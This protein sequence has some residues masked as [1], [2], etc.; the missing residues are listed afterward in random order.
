MYNKSLHIHKFKKFLQKFLL[1]SIIYI[2]LTSYASSSTFLNTP[3]H[4][5]SQFTLSIHEIKQKL[6]RHFVIGFDGT[7]LNPEI[8]L[9]L[10]TYPPAGVILFERNIASPAQTK[11]LIQ[12]IRKASPLPLVVMIDQ[13]G[14][15]VARLH[16]HNG[17]LTETPS[18]ACL[19]SQSLEASYKAGLQQG[20]LL[21]SVDINL[22]LAPVI[23][24]NIPNGYIGKRGRSFHQDPQKVIAHAQA[25]I[26]GLHDAG[27][28]SCLKHFPGHGSGQPDPHQSWTDV[29]HTYRPEELEPF[30]ACI[31]NGYADTILVGH[32]FHK[33]WDDTYPASCS[34]NVITDLLRHQLGYT[35]PILTDDLDMDA[36][37]KTV[38]DLILLS[39]QAGADLLLLCNTGAGH[40]KYF[41]NADWVKNLKTYLEN[42]AHTIQSNAAFMQYLM[43]Q[44][45]YFEGKLTYLY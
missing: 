23:D 6:A 35:G 15:P 43:E 33:E 19:G 13:E 16:P 27:V 36:A 1:S 8:A 3:P 21:K 29:T 32:L 31:K 10:K 38:Q 37:G 40:R 7:I 20:Q 5:P 41:N 45:P 28:K 2:T 42:H 4:I 34:K 11:A 18:A 12:D 44:D 14:G 17:F 25:F 26:E 24:L 22:N 39:F 9:Y 30:K